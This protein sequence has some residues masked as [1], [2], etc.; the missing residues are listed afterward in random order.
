MR[1]RRV[2]VENCCP[3]DCLM[4][5]DYDKAIVIVEQCMAELRGLSRREKKAYLLEK[6]KYCCQE[7]SAKNYFKP[8][9]RIGT[10]PGIVKSG[11]CRACFCNVYEIGHTFLDSLC[12]DV[13]DGIRCHEKSM[14]EGAVVHQV[15]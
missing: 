7:M 4:S 9:W 3:K 10:A 13:K 12:R 2:A 6:V 1:C 11:V 8:V 14:D 15:N 5:E